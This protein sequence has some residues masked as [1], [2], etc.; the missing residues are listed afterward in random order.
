MLVVAGTTG[1][2][3]A[4]AQ[5]VPRADVAAIVVA[6]VDT[7]VTGTRTSVWPAASTTGAEDTV[8]I[9]GVDDGQLDREIRRQR[10]RGARAAATPVP[11]SGTPSRR[12]CARSPVSTVTTT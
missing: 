2:T 6:P 10:R 8:A 12:G 11:P 5:A 4:I 7:P 1:L 9:A 3:D